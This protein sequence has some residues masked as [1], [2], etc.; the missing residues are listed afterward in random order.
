MLSL[1]EGNNNL[2]V[3]WYLSAAYAYYHL[4]EPFLS[5][6]DFDKM[7]KILLENYDTVV[8]RHKYLITKEDL[9]AGSL[10]LSEDD[11]PTI[12]KSA[13]RHLLTLKQDPK[14]IR[15]KAR[16]KLKQ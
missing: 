2:L 16:R 12:V 13:T 6:A 5:D 4:D 3:A 8:H 15:R 10:L 9:Q 11:Y 7:A 14:N 1:P